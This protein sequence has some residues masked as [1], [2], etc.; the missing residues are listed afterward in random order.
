MKRIP[1]T[2]G[3]FALVDDQD[4]QWLNQW[5]WRY[6]KSTNGKTGYA[7][8]NERIGP[9][10]RRHVSMHRL[11]MGAGEKQEVDHVDTNGINNQ[12]SNLRVCTRTQN[13]SNLS[14]YRTNTSGFKGVSWDKG[15]RKWAARIAA[16]GRRIHLGLFT[17]KIEAAHAYNQ[18]ALRYHG[19]FAHLNNVQEEA[20]E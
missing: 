17:N 14:A 6:H 20:A 15:A 9:G 11:I 19:E 10:K 2:K 4:Y 7:F 3:Q 1:L 12:R 5:R 13:R 16:K 18:A 8:R